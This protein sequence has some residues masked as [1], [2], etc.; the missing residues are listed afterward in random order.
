MVGGEHRTE[1]R[2]HDVEASVVEGQIFGIGDLELHRQTFGSR[3]LA[4][5]VEKSRHVVGR[6]DVRE[7]AC[8]GKRRVAVA[9]SHVE[10]AL[11][12]AHIRGF[13]E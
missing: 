4:A 2:Q 3:A 9:G 7:A 6:C 12:G 1:R 8:R 10:H 11:A 5:F 13:G